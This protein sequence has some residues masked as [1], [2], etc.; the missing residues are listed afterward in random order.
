MK[1]KQGFTL[2]E[3][4]VVVA[5]IGI[6]TGILGV[7]LSHLGTYKIIGVTKE[8]EVSLKET[9]TKS[10]T[11]NA[12]AECGKTPDAETEYLYA[13]KISCKGGTYFLSTGILE[14]KKDGSFIMVKE[15]Q[16]EKNLGKNLTITFSTS[17]VQDEGWQAIDEEGIYVSFDRCTGSTIGTKYGILRQLRYEN[18]AKNHDTI[19]FI[20]HE[21][22]RIHY[23]KK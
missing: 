20:Q 2:I 21:T 11:K 4:I 19:L 8:T 13:T 17:E 12:A 23:E 18:G 15:N 16:R 6:L 5:M 3:L 1:R 9:R 10:M 22:G 14:V 7:A